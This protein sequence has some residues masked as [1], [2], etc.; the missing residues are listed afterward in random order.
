[1]TSSKLS[2]LIAVFLIPLFP[3]VFALYRPP[4]NRYAIGLVLLFVVTFYGGYLVFDASNGFTNTKGV[5]RAA[6]E[7][8]EPEV[9]Q[10]LEDAL[11]SLRKIQPEMRLPIIDLSIPA[12]RFLSEGQYDAFKEIVKQLIDADE[13]VDIF[14]YALQRVLVHHLDPV[15]SEKPKPRPANYYA[16]RG[17]EKETSIVLSILAWKGHGN[18]FE[19]S[20]AF[21][22]AA[23]KI[24][25]PKA[26]FELLPEEACT[27]EQLDAAL[28]KLNEGS[29]K[30]K[31]WLLGAALACLM[32][33][34]E[35]TVEETE[36]FRAIADSLDCPVPP[37]VMPNDFS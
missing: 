8:A 17:L 33:D 6:L 21:Q 2:Y 35:I 12:L 4:L 10:I 30:I 14:E 37:W 1:M 29:F 5:A 27:W 13:Q 7:N 20:L 18:E 34:R 32:H 16:I 23:E 22:A 28:D 3:I 25:A 36:L 9:F 26:T 11:P 19:A 31:K 15:F 24:A